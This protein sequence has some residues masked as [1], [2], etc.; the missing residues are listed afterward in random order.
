MAIQSSWLLCR[1][2]VE[3]CPHGASPAIA[4]VGHLYE[5]HWRRTFATPIGAAAT[6]AYL[7]M[8]PDMVGLLLPLVKRLP[9]LLTWGAA[10]SGKTKQLPVTI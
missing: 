3:H 1:L 5:A 2:L 10:L 6:F 4:E 9:R 7:A 8:R